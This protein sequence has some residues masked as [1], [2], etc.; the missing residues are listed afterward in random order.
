METINLKDL[1][2]EVFKETLNNGL[3]VYLVPNNKVENYYITFN[4]KFGSTYTKFKKSTDKDYISVPNGVAHFLEHLTFYLGDKTSSSDYF[5]SLGAYSNAYTSFDITCYEVTA[6]TYFKENL[7]KLIDFV[8]TPYY[9]EE[10]V[11]NEKEIIASEVRMYEDDPIT[12]LSY[13]ALKNTLHVDNYRN[14]ISGTV[15][16]VKSITLKNIMDAYNTFYH[17]SNMFILITGNFDKDEAIKIIKDNQES[18]TFDPLFDISVFKDF[19]EESV[20]KK[21]DEFEGN[22]EID[23]VS[24]LVKLPISKFD[25]LDISKFELFKYLD[26]IINSKFSRTSILK[27]KLY[28]EGLIRDYIY[29]SVTFIDDYVLISLDAETKDPKK[30]TDLVIH[31]LKDL[32]LTEIDFTR[33]KRVGQSYLIEICDNIDSLNYNLSRQII[34]YGDIIPEMYQIYENLDYELAKIIERYINT[35]QISVTVLKKKEK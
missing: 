4:V 5:A 35:D 31:E 8:Q 28:N 3:D 11:S 16:D 2:V 27:E 32:D 6:S 34:E 30:Y 13:K 14:Q 25:D 24:I 19:E 7:V 10:L 29:K 12:K 26:I 9:T 1:D 15:E 23:K 21:Y 17:P 33:K 22:V 20:V 18:K